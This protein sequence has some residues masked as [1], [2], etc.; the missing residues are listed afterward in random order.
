MS[1]LPLSSAFLDFCSKV[2]NDD[3]SILPE[4]GKPFKIRPL[5]DKENIEL[6]D[7]LLENTNVTYLKLKPGNYTKG[8]VEAIAKYVRTS[9]H[10]QHVCLTNNGA[11]CDQTL[12]EERL[13]CFLPAIQEST[14]LKKLLMESSIIGGQ[15]NLAFKNML[16]HT[17]SL[18]SLTLKPAGHTD[19]A[20]AAVA[21][22]LKNNTSLRELTLGFPGGVTDFSTILTSLADHPHLQRLCLRG[23]GRI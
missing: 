1:N 17:Q 23:L 22:G 3:P 21:S 14:S 11:K 20:V 12:F 8:S 2:R 19:R 4:P 10:L 16:T 6:A 15:S 13:Y 18:R 9:K 5:N 7:A